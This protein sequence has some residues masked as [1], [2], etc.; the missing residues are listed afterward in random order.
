[1]KVIKIHEDAYNIA[2]A[3]AEKDSR[4]IANWVSLLIFK[5]TPEPK[6]KAKKKAPP[7][8]YPGMRQIW[9]Q[10]NPGHQWNGAESKH[11]LELQRKLIL[12]FGDGTMQTTLDLFQAFIIKLPEWYK[13]KGLSILN[14]KYNDIIKQIKQSVTSEPDEFREIRKKYS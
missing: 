11:L 9:E 13:D 3:E 10:G 4:S 2:K 7:E 6:P 5:R 14:S 12:S 1:M 8:T